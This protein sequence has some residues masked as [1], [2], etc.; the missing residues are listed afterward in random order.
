[1]VFATKVDE[2]TTGPLSTVIE[3]SQISSVIDSLKTIDW[4]DG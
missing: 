2:V 4:V 3:S 1:M